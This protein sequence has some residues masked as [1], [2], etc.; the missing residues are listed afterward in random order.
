MSYSR[1]LWIRSVGA[2][3]WQT[4]VELGNIPDGR[5]GCATHST[6]AAQLHWTPCQPRLVAVRS[7]NRAD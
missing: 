4:I 5:I 6:V 2:I 3:F 1:Q 7:G